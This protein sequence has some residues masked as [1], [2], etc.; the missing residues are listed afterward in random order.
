MLMC[1][2]FSGTDAF[3]VDEE[4][5]TFFQKSPQITIHSICQSCDSQRV[6][7]S[8]FF[9]VKTKA[10]R[11]KEAVIEQVETIVAQADLPSN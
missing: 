10:A 4:I 2:I 3:K 5:N 8:V 6:F 1:K 9:N 11:M 7:I